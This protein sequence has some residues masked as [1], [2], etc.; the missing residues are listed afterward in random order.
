MLTENQIGGEEQS[1]SDSLEEASRIFN[2]TMDEIEVEQE[3]YWNSLSKDDQLKVFCSVMRRLK[4]AELDDQGSYRYC[5]YEVFGFGSESYAQ[6][7]LAG[8]LALHNRITTDEEDKFLWEHRKSV[9]KSDKV[10]CCNHNCNQGRT[11]PLR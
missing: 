10:E 1:L 5:L 11:C 7:Q 2:E 9:V 6:A 8:Y 4:K 3:S